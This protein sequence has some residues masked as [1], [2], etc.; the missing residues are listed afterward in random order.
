MTLVVNSTPLDPSQNSYVSLTEMLDYVS[1]RVAD[2]SVLTAWQALSAAQQALYVVNA[3]RSLDTAC[4]WIGDRYSRDQTMHWP[5]VNA[6]VQGFLLDVLTVPVRVKE[7]TCEMA[8]WSMQNN[9]ATSVTNQE[10]FERIWVGPLK[11]NFNDNTGNPAYQYFPDV[12]AYL[13][14]ELGTLNNPNVPGGN[15]AKMVRLQ[16]A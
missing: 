14:S 3:S 16:R 5:R 8:I 10:S 11:I 4:T 2:A 7:A 9:G 13:L 12:V 6:W 15:T 1:T